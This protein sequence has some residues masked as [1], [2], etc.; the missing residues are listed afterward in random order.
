MKHQ[1]P[2]AVRIF[3][4]ICVVFMT[5]SLI[6]VY[7]VY[8]FAPTQEAWEDNNVSENTW[9]VQTIDLGEVSVDAQ[10]VDEII[11]ELDPENPEN[12]D[13]PI[14]VTEDGEIDEMDRTFEVQLENG[15]TE[16]V[17]QWDFWDAIQITQ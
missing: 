5:V 1:K 4:R 3:I 7:V 6:G 10:A 2:L 8:M 11:P 16:V 14:L 13:A 15:E 12:T 17:R 9:D